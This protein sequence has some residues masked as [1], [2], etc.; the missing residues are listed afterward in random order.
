[1]SCGLPRRT[2]QHYHLKRFRLAT[3]AT[4]ALNVTN[5]P[6]F[7]KHLDA[8]I[9]DRGNVNEH[10]LTTVIRAYKAEAVILLVPSAGR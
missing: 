2:S 3:A 1:M 4:E 7:A 6:V 9:G 10:V 5:T 8:W